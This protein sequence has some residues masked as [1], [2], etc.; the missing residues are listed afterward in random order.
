MASKKLHALARI[1]E[2]MDTG[3]W[4][5]LMKAFLSYHVIY[6]KKKKSK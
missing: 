2:Y 4:G 6:D 5:M 1:P 3:K